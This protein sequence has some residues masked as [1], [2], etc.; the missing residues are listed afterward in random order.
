M[1][2]DDMQTHPDH[3]PWTK[4]LKY[5]TEKKKEKTPSHSSGCLQSIN[6]YTPTPTL[7][8]HTRCLGMLL[9]LF[10]SGKIDL[11]CITNHQ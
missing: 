3:S 4:Q 1:Y 7:W 11:G 10:V 5:S 9:L 2:A 8:D 6:K